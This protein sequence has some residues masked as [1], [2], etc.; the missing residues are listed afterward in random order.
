[1][2]A[3]VAGGPNPTFDSEAIPA[4]FI[5]DRS[6]RVVIRHM[7]AANWDTPEVAGFLEKLLKTKAP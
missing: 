5:L 7:G 1:V 3:L 4:T 6:G 2:K